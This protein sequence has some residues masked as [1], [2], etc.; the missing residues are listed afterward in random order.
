[1]WYMYI[2]YQAFFCPLGAKLRAAKNSEISKLRDFFGE[3]EGFLLKISDFRLFLRRKRTKN[4]LLGVK[5][6]QTQAKSEQNSEK[7]GE[8]QSFGYSLVKPSPQ[9]GQKKSLLQYE[10]CRK[11]EF[12]MGME[13]GGNQ[14]DALGS[15]GFRN[16]L[17]FCSTL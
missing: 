15:Q 1:M 13:G 9:S 12:G 2:V 14:N 10:I 8:T 5:S 3:T 7:I 4:G 16:I 17:D 6:P 11:N